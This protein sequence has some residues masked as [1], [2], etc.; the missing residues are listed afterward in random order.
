MF[1]LMS[2]FLLMFYFSHMTFLCVVYFFFFFSSRRRHTRF[3]LVTGVQTCA[4]P[5]YQPG[6]RTGREPERR[7]AGGGDRR[8]HPPPAFLEEHDPGEPAARH[9]APCGQGGAARRVHRAHPGTGAPRLRGR[10]LRPAGPGGAR[11]ARRH[12]PRHP[13]VRRARLRGRSDPPPRPVAAHPSGPP[14]PP[15]PPPHPQLGTAADMLKSAQRPLLLCG[16]GVHISRAAAAVTAFAEATNIP[17]AHTMSG[18]GAIACT[19][20]LSAGLFGR[21]D[22]IANTLIEEADLLFVVGCKLGEIATKRFTVPPKGKTIIHQIGRAH[23]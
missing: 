10:P 18:K 12:L 17:V 16:G 3:A 21:Y 4:L 6:D 14:L 22:R 9:P 11:R 5:I 15:P 7:G 19:S 13:S 20:A 23:V 8:R 2:Y 1:V